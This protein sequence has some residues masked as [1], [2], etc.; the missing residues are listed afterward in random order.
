[1]HVVTGRMSFVGPRPLTR[2]ELSVHYGRS[3]RKILSAKPGLT[4][5]W[6]VM[7]RSRLSYRQRA[8]LDAFYVEKQSVP[9]Y[10]GILA[11]TI[12]QVL[13]GKDSW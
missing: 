8:R 1:M 9:L 5:L 7:G 11:R 4:G 2:T 13:A 10:F 6:Q 12:P 3:A